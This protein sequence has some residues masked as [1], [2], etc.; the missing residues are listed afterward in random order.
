V[1]H[2]RNIILTGFMGTG[3]SAVGKKL[4]VRLGRKF[5]DTDALIAQEAGM[6]IARLFSEKGEPYFR[7]LEQEVIA[8]VCLEDEAIIATGGGAIV[9]EV[10]AQRLKASGI[11]ICL[12]AAPEVIL[13]RVQE[14]TTRPLLLAD[15]PLPKIHALL[16]ARAEAYAR[17]HAMIDT[18]RLNVDQVVEAVQVVVEKG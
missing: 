17:A 6:P 13:A 14:D 1:S 15:D 4:A 7:E 9:K 3:K 5:I 11:V 18:S 16:A 8:R 2:A 10:N 12:T